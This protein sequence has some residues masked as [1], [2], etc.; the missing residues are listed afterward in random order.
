MDLTKKR[1]FVIGVG[2][3]S[4]KYITEYS[5][6]VIE[7]SNY[8]VGYRYTLSTISHLIDR[9]RQ[10]VF[11]VTMRNQEE[12]YQH[13]FNDLMKDGDQCIVPF[14]GDVNFS[15]SEV[16]DR[17]LQLFGDSNVELIPGISSIQ[18]A[19]AKSMIPLD[20]AAIIT[21]HVT[22]DIEEKKLDLVKSVADKKSVIL[23]PRPWPSNPSKSF[24]PSEISLFLKEKDIDTSKIDVWV[25]ENLTDDKK[26]T[27]YKGKLD[28]LENKKFSDLSV[29]V[30]DQYIRQTYLDF[31][32]N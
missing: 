21:F 5:K 9:S 20:K 23:V 31:N 26:E 29:M 27:I 6:E 32:N 19:S 12:V 13:I 10:Q 24:M 16:V 14:T 1:L 11:E 25:F 4:R 22:D 3:G 17:L 2:P 15:E 18:I 28:S 7:K 8:V 30:I